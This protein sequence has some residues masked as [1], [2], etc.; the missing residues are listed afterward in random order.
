MMVQRV[1]VRVCVERGERV[2]L[3]RAPAALISQ[4]ERQIDIGKKV[5]SQPRKVR[6]IGVE[7]RGEL[8]IVPRQSRI[9]YSERLAHRLILA[10]ERLD[11][12]GRR[13]EGQA[14]SQNRLHV[15]TDGLEM[16]PR[17]EHLGVR[18]CAPTN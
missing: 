4:V 11:Q 2:C 12:C 14:V 7:R 6:F 16:N 10:F 17:R 18:G 5:C 8:S 13:I 3:V 9:Q 15:E 1:C